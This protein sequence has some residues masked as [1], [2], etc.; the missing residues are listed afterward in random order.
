MKAFLA[1]ILF[2][3]PMFGAWEFLGSA[4]SSY[5]KIYGDANR[6]GGHI[7][8][9]WVKHNAAEGTPVGNLSWTNNF[10]GC[11][12]FNDTGIYRSEYYARVGTSGESQ[13]YITRTAG[14]I[15]AG[16]W[17]FIVIHRSSGLI[18]SLHTQNVHTVVSS[19]TIAPM[20]NSITT[21]STSVV[22]GYWFNSVNSPDG[23]IQR[24]LAGRVAYFY[25]FNFGFLSY[26]RLFNLFLLNDFPNEYH[27]TT[28]NVVVE[29][30]ESV[31]ER[32]GLSIDMPMGGP[33][34]KL[35][36]GLPVPRNRMLLNQ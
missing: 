36:E 3:M 5:V 31:R 24:E 22:G 2:S 30:T 28:N 16:R 25:N 26:N 34:L 35:S 13:N 15:N 18:M 1:V 4:S 32:S 9:A 33:R 17:A 6:P 20:T 8:G 23:A 10:R 14:P 29:F 7:Y 11:N 27:L 21:L 19:E 12:I